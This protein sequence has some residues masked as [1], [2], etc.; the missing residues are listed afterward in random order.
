MKQLYDFFM[1]PDTLPYDFAEWQTLPFSQR[2]KKVCQAWALQ[3]FGAPLFAPVFY[4]LKIA[5]YVYMWFFFCSYS[6]KLGDFSSVSDWWFQM[7][8]LGKAIF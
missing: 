3:G 2:A 4:A 7:D 6:T 8:A 1:R 5:F